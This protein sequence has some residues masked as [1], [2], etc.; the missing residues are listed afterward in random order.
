M[1]KLFLLFILI[2]GFA[3]GQFKVTESSADYT[4]VGKSVSGVTISQNGN[5]AKI[6][7]ADY[8][9]LIG[10]TNVLS[11]TLFYTFEFSIEPDTLDKMYEIIIDHFITKKVELLTLEFPEGKM[12]L[13]FYKSF[14]TYGFNFKFDNNTTTLDKNADMKRQTNAISE[15]QL[16]KLF[17][18]D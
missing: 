1:K 13:N 6:D 11:P 2:S 15:K 10:K 4:V 18:K 12:Y 3:F 5:K 16:K 8:N 17:G 9:T 14:G 7:Y